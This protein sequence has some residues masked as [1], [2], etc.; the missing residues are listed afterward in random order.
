M[1]VQRDQLAQTVNKDAHHLD[2]QVESNGVL[3]AFKDGVSRCEVI[4]GVQRRNSRQATSY[5]T[6]L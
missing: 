2:K 3:K 6:R 4:H 5:K 1:S